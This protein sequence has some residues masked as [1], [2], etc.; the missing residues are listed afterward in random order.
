MAGQ[1]FTDCLCDLSSADQSWWNI[2]AKMIGPIW[3]SGF[4]AEDGV[5]G[6]S[7][8][9][10]GHVC[11]SVTSS[12]FSCLRVVPTLL[13]RPG[14]LYFPE[15]LSGPYFA[16]FLSCRFDS[17]VFWAFSHDI[18]HSSVNHALQILEICLLI[19]NGIDHIV[20]SDAGIE[21]SYHAYIQIRLIE[22][23]TLTGMSH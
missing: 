17:A 6:L 11:H 21:D 18:L 5:D 23:H 2:R 19:W 20:C 7:Q 4:V 14:T 13:T 16:S 9:Q 3:Q 8:Q 15:F 12:D 22:G 10:N 1:D